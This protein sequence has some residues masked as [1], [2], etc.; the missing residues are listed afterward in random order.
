MGHVIY[1][2]NHKRMLFGEESD[3]MPL[4]SFFIHYFC[5]YENLNSLT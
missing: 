4:I 1:Q 2:I 3:G 5:N